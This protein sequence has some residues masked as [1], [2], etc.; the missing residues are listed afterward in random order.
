MR[1]GFTLVEV[2]VATAVFS[3]LAILLLSSFTGVTRAREALVSR[4][5]ADR[6]V[7]LILDR[8][9]TELSGAFGSDRVSSAG[10]SCAQDRFAGTEAS[11]LAFTAF[12]LPQEGGTRPAADVA[13]IRYFTRPD[14]EGRFLSLYR[15]ES[16]L[17]LVENRIPVRRALLGDR[18]LGFRIELFDGTAWVSAWPPQGGGKGRL[19]QRIAAVLTDSGGAEFRRVF[20]LPLAGQEATLPLSGRRP[21]AS[22]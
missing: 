19:P 17:P 9:G 14:A 7:R 1:R 11:D 21:G 16:S 8:L 2:L 12:V 18:L 22:P 6:Q 3:L 13:K 15:E 10:L 20:R 4:A 5:S